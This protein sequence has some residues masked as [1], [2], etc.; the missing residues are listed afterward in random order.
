MVPIV[1]TTT[2]HVQGST[3]QRRGQAQEG[4]HMTASLLQAAQ[5]LIRYTMDAQVKMKTQLNEQEKDFS[6]LAS[7]AVTTAEANGALPP[8]SQAQRKSIE[9]TLSRVASSMS[10]Q[11]TDRHHDCG[12]SLC[13]FGFQL[14]NAF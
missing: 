1:I 4:L 13:T 8:M 14:E 11:G 5:T 12:K 10:W 2:V 9:K 3:G 7:A 6:K